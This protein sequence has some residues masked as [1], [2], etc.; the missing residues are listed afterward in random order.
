V[1]TTSEA[2]LRARVEVDCGDPAFAELADLLRRTSRLTE[3]LEVC[4]AGLSRNPGVYRGRLTLARIYVERGWHP[5]AVREIEVLSRE[6]PTNEALQRL[7][8]K[9]AADGGTGGAGSTSMVAETEL[10]LE[11][12]ELLEREG[13]GEDR[14]QAAR[15]G[16]E[17]GGKR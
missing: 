14:E 4:L 15:A 2:T 5:F 7:R 13:A 9:L 3:A 11:A 6:L 8:A 12:L 17:K 1:S 16:R 10:D